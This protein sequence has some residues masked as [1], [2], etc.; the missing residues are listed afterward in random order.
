MSW[1]MPETGARKSLSLTRRAFGQSEYGR[2]IT[3][4]LKCASCGIVGRDSGE[5]NSRLCKTSNEKKTIIKLRRV[6]DLTL[7]RPVLESEDALYV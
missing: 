1:L 4:L 7:A 5:R 2:A 3:R 6:A